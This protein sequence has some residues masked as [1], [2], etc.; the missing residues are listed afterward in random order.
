[1]AFFA[2]EKQFFPS[3]INGPRL[4]FGKVTLADWILHQHLP[5]PVKVPGPFL[6]R[7]KSLSYDPIDDSQ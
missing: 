6:L 2:A 7:K 3:E 1:M 5:C 4:A